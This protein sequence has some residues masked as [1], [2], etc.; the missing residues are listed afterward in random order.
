MEVKVV[1]FWL[2]RVMPLESTNIFVASHGTPSYVDP[3]YHQ[4]YH[5]T[6]K[7]DVYNFYVALEELIL[8][9]K[10]VNTNK[11]SKFGSECIDLA[12]MAIPKFQNGTLHE[13][14]DLI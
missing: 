8:R 13:V 11:E 3:M 12:I 7:S 5:L 4:M 2:S 6:D 9:K 1:D 14:V 10:A